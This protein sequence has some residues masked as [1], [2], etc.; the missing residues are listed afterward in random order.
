[1][2]SKSHITCRNAINCYQQRSSGYQEKNHFLTTSI[3]Y[4][5]HVHS[6]YIANET[7]SLQIQNMGR[8]QFC[9]QHV[10]KVCL[11][12][13]VQCNCEWQHKDGIHTGTVCYQ[14]IDAILKYEGVLVWEVV[15]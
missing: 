1:M 2:V 9:S 14:I 11:I 7:L 6:T 13:P 10:S 5:I 15:T 8:H 12:N 3:Q 4:C